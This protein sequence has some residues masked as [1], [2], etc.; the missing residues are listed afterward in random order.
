M[1]FLCFIALSISLVLSGSDALARSR[2][3]RRASSSDRRH[4]S[5]HG[6]VTRERGRRGESVSRRGR[7]GREEYYARGSRRGR[8]GR[9]RYASRRG[10]RYEPRETVAA[11][12][13]RP[14]SGIPTE[15]VTEIQNA[16]IKGGY[17]SGPASGQY[18]DATSSAMRRFQSANGMQAT[19][20]PSAASLKRLGVA[21]GSND[22]YAV[23]I[24][25]ATQRESTPAPDAAKP[26]P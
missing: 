14:A 25:S 6:R 21:K 10:R 16:L 19:G 15:R 4:S 11:S 22:G 17:L 3:S 8:H 13:S 20:S 23:P 24:K 2:A 18:D 7:H 12:Y 5:S 26:R 9:D 1:R